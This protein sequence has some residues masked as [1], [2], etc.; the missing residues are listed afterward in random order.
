M[1]KPL[2]EPVSQIAGIV[3]KLFYNKLCIVGVWSAALHFN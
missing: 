3:E 1:Q 2:V